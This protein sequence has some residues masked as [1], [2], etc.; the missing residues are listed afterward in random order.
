[1]TRVADRSTFPTKTGDREIM[2]SL[3][4]KPVVMTDPKTGERVKTK[5]RKWWGRFKDENGV[6]R[7]V[8]LA[9]D[10]MAAQAMLNEL[11]KKV[12][13]RAAGVVDR[14]DEHRKR[15]IDEHLVDF[16]RYLKAKGVS[17][18]Q[19]KL[20]VYRARRVVKHCKAKLI[21]ELSA[22]RV[23]TCLAD[24]RGQG[25]SIQTSNHYLRAIKQFSRW[26]VKDRRAGDD[27]LAF[28][29]ML[30]VSTDR[31]H[32]R[33]PLSVADLT[34]LLKA[35]QTGPVVL[36]MN[37]PDRAMLYAVAAYTGLRASELASLTPESFAFD[38]EPP[39]VTVRAAYSK[40]RREDVLPLHPSLVA[41][42]R[43]WLAAK[44]RSKPIWPG[45]WA[46][47]KYAGKMLQYD[48]AA[49]GIPYVDENGLYAD[50]HALRHTFI[51]NMVKSGVHPK[52]AQSLARHSTI[53][54]T[55]NVYTS[56][57]VHDQAS[58]LASLPAV[59]DLE[60][61]VSTA[62]A[63]RA[64]GKDGPKKVPAMVP[65]GAENGAKRPASGASHSAPDCTES[66]DGAAKPRRAKNAK[67][68]GENGGF[69]VSLHR[70]ASNFPAEREGFEP[71]LDL[72]P[73]RFS[74]PVHSA[75]LP[76][77][78]KPRVIVQAATR[79]RARLSASNQDR[80]TRKVDSQSLGRHL[81]ETT[82]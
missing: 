9:A 11:V 58:A 79:M 47:A 29:S 7:R 53:E 23:Q 42:V 77:L 45:N 3:Y 75:A 17:D 66:G 57:S 71:S 59:P 51:T 44:P 46:K 4:K 70:S 21:G 8:P 33:R 69:C 31:R 50:F 38:G 14:Y 78:L 43:P 15:P 80:Q 54:L 32:D 16:E 64:T 65:R 1:M 6:E 10:K 49:A 63:L 67:T 68:P 2:A 5:S 35:A 22:S 76:P 26:L 36:K 34:A 25:L 27:P 62:G 61:P 18:E 56:L 37:G 41:L 74:R 13:R 20:V 72:R 12:E 30:N 73:G 52:T 60:A 40:H 28:I 19:V 82:S 24:L 55:M 48:L 81:S 39:T